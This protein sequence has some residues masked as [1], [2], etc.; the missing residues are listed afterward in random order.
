MDKLKGFQE[1]TS[2]RRLRLKCIIFFYVK[3]ELK[4]KMNL[5]WIKR[6][7]FQKLENEQMF[8]IPFMFFLELLRV[9]RASL[10]SLIDSIAASLFENKNLGKND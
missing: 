5:S 7:L 8:N 4:D 9:I 6:R 2:S 10:A 3:T 1:L